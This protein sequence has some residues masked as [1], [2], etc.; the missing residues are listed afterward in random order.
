MSIHDPNW[1]YT[2]SFATDIRKTFAAARK[3]AAG[4]FVL[5]EREAQRRPDHVSVDRHCERPARS[6]FAPSN[7]SPA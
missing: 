7:K 6:L 1:K 3:I 5:G 4:Q 2:P